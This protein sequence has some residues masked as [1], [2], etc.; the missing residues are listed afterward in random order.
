MPTAPPIKRVPE[1]ELKIPLKADAAILKENAFAPLCPSPHFRASRPLPPGAPFESSDTHPSEKQGALCT[2]PTIPT[3]PLPP[4]PTHP[5]LH[6]TPPPNRCR[7]PPNRRRRSAR[8][9]RP[10][11]SEPRGVAAESSPPSAMLCV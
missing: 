4:H 8:H 2:P 11:P 3:I 10:S 1:V 9:P 5:T 7:P 6:P